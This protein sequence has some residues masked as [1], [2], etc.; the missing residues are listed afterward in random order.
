PINCL[1]LF[2]IELVGFVKICLLHGLQ[3]ASGCVGSSSNGSKC[4]LLS[5]DQSDL[6]SSSDV[7]TSQ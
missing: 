1:T 2:V 7:S 3:R 4:S 6:A 5:E